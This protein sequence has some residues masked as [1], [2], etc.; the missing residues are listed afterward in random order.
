V[1]GQ[2]LLIPW[3]K[4]LLGKAIVCH[5]VK[6]FLSFYGTQLLVTVLRETATGLC[7]EPVE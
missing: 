6:N 7:A 5:L 3:I 1:K 4:V 2:T